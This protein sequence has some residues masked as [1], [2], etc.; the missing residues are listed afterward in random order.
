MS[1][2]YGYGKVSQDEDAWSDLEDENERP[3]PEQDKLRGLANRALDVVDQ[4]KDTVV[5]KSQTIV[6]NIRKVNESKEP[7]LGKARH[8][9]PCIG[10]FLDLVFV[11]FFLSFHHFS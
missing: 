7:K 4:V 3:P 11:V 5:T 8:R 2:R 6:D 9:A 1:R 10:V